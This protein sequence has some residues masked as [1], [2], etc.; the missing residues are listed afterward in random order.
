VKRGLL[1]LVAACPL[2]L[3]VPL[4]RAVEGPPPPPIAEALASAARQHRPLVLEFYTDWCHPCQDMDRRVFPD[5]RVKAA[6][7]PAIR[8]WT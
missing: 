6:L 3:V 1:L 5:A 2:L 7:A 8:S 4:A